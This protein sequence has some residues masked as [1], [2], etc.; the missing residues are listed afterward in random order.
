M[1]SP[2]LIF[3][4]IFL[5][6]RIN[7]PA[8][9]TPC[10]LFITLVLFAA[11]ASQKMSLE[12]AKK[13]TV[14]MGDE[15][16]AP[17][18]RRIN[19]V[20]AVLEQPVQFDQAIVSKFIALADKSPPKGADNI[21]LAHFF[22]KR[23]SAAFQLGRL[24]QVL[25]D[26]RTALL[27]AQKAKMEDY[28]FLDTLGE[29]EFWGGNYNRAIELL[30]RSLSKGDSLPAYTSLVGLYSRIG[31]LESAEKLKNKGVALCDQV[32]LASR[33]RNKWARILAAK[34][35]AYF[36]EAQGR[37]A[38]AEEQW[39]MAIKLL[40]SKQQ[41]LALTYIIFKTWLADN[42]R[43]QNR[44]TEAE[45]EG[46]QALKN[47]IGLTGKASLATV[48]TIGHLGVTLQKQGRLKDAQ[49][50]INCGL[51]II[52]NSGIS[53]D[54]F[55]MGEIRMNYGN[56]L[57]DQQKF[58]EA[59]KMYNLA[60]ADMIT[61]QPIYNKLL[62][63]NP[64]L[65]LSLLMTG[66]T[67]EATQFI[68]SAHELYVKNFGE[69][70]YW[71]AEIS[72]LR[73]M[74]NARKKRF[75]HAI[76]DFSESIPILLKT[77]ISREGDF[78]RKQRF[79]IIVENYVDLLAQIYEN[80]LDEELGI[81]S[82][83]EAF[84]LAD[85]IRG[86]LVQ[87]AMGAS[88]ARV[89]AEEPEL[90]D[91]VRREQDTQ[92][93]IRTLQSMLTENLA[94][95]EDQQDPAAIK[96]MALKIKTFSKARVAL[97][98]E[99]NGQF[100]KYA[101]FINP[102]PATPAVSQAYLRPNEALISIY[103]SKNHTYVW[104]L[105]YKGD[106]RFSIV[107]LGKNTIARIISHLRTSLDPK[108][109]TF[110]DIPEFDLKLAHE[111][112]CNLL[113]P[114]EDGWN[115]AS[116]LIIVAPGLLGQLP[117]S[118]LPTS[119]VRLA[120]QKDELFGNYRQVPWLIRKVSL[121]RLPSVSSLITLRKLPEADRD[122]KV[123][124]GFGDPFFNKEQLASAEIEKAMQKIELSSHDKKLNLRGIRITK[125]GNLD[126]V[127]IVTSRLES[128]N[129]LPDT[130]DEIK[131][132]A[133][134]LNADPSRDVFL[135]KSAT[136]Y[137]IKTMDLSDRQIL[138]FATHALL[139]GDLDGL[140]QPALAFSSPT[141]TGSDE[142]GLLTCGE[143]LKIKLNADW[144]ILSAC[145]TG[146]AHGVAAEAYSGLGRAFFYAGTRAILVSMWPVETTSAQKLINR[147]FQFQ[148]KDNKLSRAKAFQNSMLE[149]I[150]DAGLKDSVSGKIISSYAHPLFWAPFI[151][152]GESGCRTN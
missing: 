35:T 13:I 77:N 78:S 114:V 52:E 57:A 138:A 93:Q 112:Y 133:E 118:V 27:Y 87:S 92:Q 150:D 17:P 58:S 31:D 66:R 90:A 111:L 98:E 107:K 91:L 99:I 2:I 56:V 116:E 37:F 4:K 121:S 79:E 85:A 59:M 134:A 43:K 16:S 83:A 143:I 97:L 106:M 145:N 45:L 30:E 28:R 73:G 122:R 109:K 42:L 103:P 44:L 3:K 26:L 61:N 24:N 5:K 128:L 88:G 36:L 84:K 108:P 8:R 132:V 19:D 10:I 136:E 23:S 9:S 151:I 1:I 74:L 82:S 113:K 69:N 140:D 127:A 48:Y 141:I 139:P 33:A 123:F 40:P 95:P 119:P 25:E 130:A 120:K 148:Q 71:T 51:R 142:D 147:L 67:E 131:G 135:G 75:K 110:G 104:A 70:H 12:E 32:Y 41:D 146:V 76:K 39:R 29:M 54:S 80:R 100:P 126:S 65:M 125:A 21:D 94:L 49:K 63:R 144:V 68:S 152:V 18:P 60:R 72:G 117:F 20:L 47:A 38:E 7:S 64:N 149:L 62:A 46:R 15:S 115:D 86:H 96:R 129:R 50:L 137:K 105:P 124:A 101:D 34:M 22:K 81:D 53:D 55:L 89:A 102:Q 11:C 14:T 6:F